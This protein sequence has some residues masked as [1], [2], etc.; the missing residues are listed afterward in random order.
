M[1][2]CTTLGSVAATTVIPVVAIPIVANDLAERFLIDIVL[3]ALLHSG[4]TNGYRPSDFLHTLMNIFRLYKNQAMNT[5]MAAT[6]ADSHTSPYSPIAAAVGPP[7][8][9]SAISR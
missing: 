6:Q 4:F 9:A 5:L 8:I 1:L 7:A 2:D 3:L